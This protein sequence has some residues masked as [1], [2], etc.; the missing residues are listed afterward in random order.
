MQIL[1]PTRIQ[2]PVMANPDPPPRSVPPMGRS[3]RRRT[4]PAI[5]PPAV[6]LP[7]CGGVPRDW[8]A[9][10]G[11]RRREIGRFFRRAMDRLAR[12]EPEWR[13]GETGRPAGSRRSG[14]PSRRRSHPA[15]VGVA[16]APSRIAATPTGRDDGGFSGNQTTAAGAAP[17]TL[18]RRPRVLPGRAPDLGVTDASTRTTEPDGQA[19]ATTTDRVGWRASVTA[20]RGGRARHGV[21]TTGGAVTGRTERGLAAGAAGGA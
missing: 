3:T 15:G 19:W 14:R 6:P 9:P 10:R 18:S 21:Q 17:G 13:R 20:E 2:A 5:K 12:N 4:R 8:T 1:G 16:T 7:R 11:I